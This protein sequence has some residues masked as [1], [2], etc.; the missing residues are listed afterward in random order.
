[1]SVTWE[2]RVLKESR[3]ARL[4]AAAVQWVL[5]VICQQAKAVQCCESTLCSLGR[6]ACPRTG[7]ATPV[8]V[9]LG[10]EGIG[11]LDGFVGTWISE[12]VALLTWHLGL[13]RKNV[14][15]S[16]PSPDSS[17]PVYQTYR[18]SLKEFVL[19]HLSHLSLL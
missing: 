12:M 4:T 6:G 14:L 10:R 7:F 9:S 8:N 13:S 15:L 17:S 16:S 5:S 11:N 19:S 1:M 2:G 18:T 3:R